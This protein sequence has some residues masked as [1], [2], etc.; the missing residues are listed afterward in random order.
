MLYV[1]RYWMHSMV[2]PADT[3]DEKGK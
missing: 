2:S 1:R 3:P